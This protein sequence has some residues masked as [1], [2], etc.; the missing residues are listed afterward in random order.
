MELRRRRGAKG[1]AALA[2]ANFRIDPSFGE[3]VRGDLAKSW[4]ESLKSV[5]YDLPGLIEWERS[6][7]FADRRVL[8]VQ[9]ES[10]EVGAAWLSV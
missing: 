8:I 7:F 4:S 10:R 6:D 5:E 2:L 1:S 3:E 9:S